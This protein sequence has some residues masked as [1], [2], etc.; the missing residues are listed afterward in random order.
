[1]AVGTLEDIVASAVASAAP[2]A[3]PAPPAEVIAL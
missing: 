1:M 2:A 3:L